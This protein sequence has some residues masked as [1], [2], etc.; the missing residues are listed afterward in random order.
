MAGL[1]IE[2]AVSGDPRHAS[3]VIKERL[4]QL[5]A[6]GSAEF[7]VKEIRQ[8]FAETASLLLGTVAV[9]KLSRMGISEL[10]H[11]LRELAGLQKDLTGAQSIL[12][13]VGGEKLEPEKVDDGKLEKLAKLL[14]LSDK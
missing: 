5:P 10:R 6:V 7:E 3:E 13:N 4:E 9:L 12:V 14:G 11:L 1:E 2:I 8:G